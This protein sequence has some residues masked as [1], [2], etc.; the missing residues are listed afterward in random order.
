[1]LTIGR[2]MVYRPQ[3]AISQDR[4][5]A[6]TKK[7]WIGTMLTG[8]HILLTYTCNF[9]C[10]H[11]FLYCGPHVGGTFT[12]DELRKVIHEAK[13]IGTVEWIYFEG[14]EPFLYYPLLLKGVELSGEIGFKTGV[15][16]N[17]YGAVSDADADLWLRPLADLG[18][19]YLSISDDSF[20]HAGEG[21]SSAKRAL[22]AAKELKIPTSPIC[23]QQ[24]IVEAMPGDGL[25]KGD[26]V[27]SGG[28]MFKG[29]AVEKL[30]PGLPRKSCAKFKDCP[31]EDLSSPSRI[32]IDSYGNVQLCQGISIGNMWEIPLSTLIENYNAN[33]HPICG[34]IANGGPFL[35]GREYDMKHE[36]EYVDECHFCYLLRLALI[37]RFPQ[38]LA[39]RQVY[40]LEL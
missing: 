23:I 8:I 17:A 24:P 11:C 33:S 7:G 3:Y 36:E 32:H 14:G 10:D 29:R 22:R 5:I 40:G 9:E 1:M 26:P 35:L 18:L 25:E 31:H 28:A 16:T 6:A 12:L 13:Q 15:V 38:Y 39:P 37:D 30:T 27:I 4:G 21:E 19:S 34:P 20:H 2:V